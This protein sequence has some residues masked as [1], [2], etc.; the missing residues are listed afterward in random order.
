MADDLG[1]GRTL[2]STLTRLRSEGQQLGRRV[3]AYLSDRGVGRSAGAD[4]T[5]GP[6]D[7]AVADVRT[8]V[9]GTWRGL[10]VL[11]R[12]VTLW[13]GIILLSAYVAW[14]I[15]PNR[16]VAKGWLSALL[17]MSLVT[18]G[19]RL[20]PRCRAKTSGVGIEH[21]FLAAATLL[22][23]VVLLVSSGPMSIRRS[24]GIGLVAIG[25]FTLFVVA[26]RLIV[27]RG[28][29]RAVLR[30]MVWLLVTGVA[31]IAI[32]LVAAAAGSP[33]SQ[34]LSATRQ[35][36]AS[37]AGRVTPQPSPTEPD[38]SSK[39]PGEDPGDPATSSGSTD[40]GS[41]TPK[42]PDVS[43][44]G[45]L[46]TSQAPSTSSDDAASE[47]LTDPENNDH[48]SSASRPAEKNEREEA[49]AD[50]E[51]EC[52][53]TKKVHFAV[54]PQGYVRSILVGEWVIIAPLVKP[55]LEYL[56][57]KGDVLVPRRPPTIE[58]GKVSQKF[59]NGVV[60][61]ARIDD[62]TPSPVRLNPDATLP[63]CDK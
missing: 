46:P 39:T 56:T 24:V 7:D 8:A 44:S 45:A 51:I 9:G 3:A 10:D 53:P 62:T 55:W 35:Q 36:P 40:R 57:R 27:T 33:T 38:P 28:V 16:D 42:P 6:L 2:N 52:I 59:T 26:Y 29:L 23:V 19:S 49:T 60:L 37:E 4:P 5:A 20:L 63:V 34:R 43:S 50:E 1:T 17:V 12:L 48:S 13:Q 30:R 22:T 32:G 21:A 47:S 61:S 25:I 41:E 15:G 54:D 11:G 14:W 18:L 58:K 31:S